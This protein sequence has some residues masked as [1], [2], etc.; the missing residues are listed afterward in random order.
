[1]LA[2][3]PLSLLNVTFEPSRLDAYAASDIDANDADAALMEDEL[4][5]PPHRYGWWA[6]RT[7]SAGSDPFSL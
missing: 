1:M 7:G 2:D 4:A 3:A 5:L 6:S